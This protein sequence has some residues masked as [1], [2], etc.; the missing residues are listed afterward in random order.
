MLTKEK[1]RERMATALRYAQF[2]MMF[3]LFMFIMLLSEM[4]INM[5]A[6]VFYRD[7]VCVYVYALSLL[8]CGAGYLIFPI[9]KKLT[10]GFKENRIHIVILTAYILIFMILLKT[11][12][13][14]IFLISLSLSMMCIGYIGALTFY[15]MCLA[16]A[17][18]KYLFRIM[19]I[20]LF[21]AVMGLYVI[22]YLCTQASTVLFI[23]F[24]ACILYACFVYSFPL[25]YSV[26]RKMRY[27]AVLLDKKC[28][29]LIIIVASISLLLSI[30]QNAMITDITK[31]AITP[32]DWPKLLYALFMLIGGMIGDKNKPALAVSC[33]VSMTLCALGFLYSGINT[34]T[35]YLGLSIQYAAAGLCMVYIGASPIQTAQYTDYSSLWASVG[36]YGKNICIAL[37]AVPLMFLNDVIPSVWIMVMD[38][39][40]VVICSVGM[41]LSSKIKHDVIDRTDDAYN[42][43]KQICISDFANKYSLDLNE[44][45]VA[46]ELICGEKSIKRIAFE[47]YL[48]ERKVYAL[49]ASVYEK[50]NT[51]NLK[52]LLY[53]YYI[54]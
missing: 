38:L 48:S 32:N 46:G 39:I 24:P 43:F 37:F 20:S 53:L 49:L 11:Q 42:E 52:K 18:S 50:T 35:M 29:Y 4:G 16:L 17:G 13:A 27:S 28:T 41:Y 26:P 34:I 8:A 14:A 9:T 33:M 23:L 31:F 10:A 7:S 6:G 1:N 15:Y 3:G 21:I 30:G 5:R 44:K 45:R 2:I 19:G 36:A 54:S 40:L 25:N 12:S 51:D 47:M 22:R